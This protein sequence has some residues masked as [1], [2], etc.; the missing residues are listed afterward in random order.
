MKLYAATV[1][2]SVS[3]NG[4]RDAAY[5]LSAKTLKN[6]NFDLFHAHSFQYGQIRFEYGQKLGI[7]VVTT[8]H[9]KIF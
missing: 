2:D 1:F 9:T 3:E 4:F 7:P 5:Q 6:G 8:F